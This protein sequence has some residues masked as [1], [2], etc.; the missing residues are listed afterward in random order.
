M[1]NL[2]K[3]ILPLLLLCYVFSCKTVSSN[4]ETKNPV[5][6]ITITGTA[7]NAK[8]GAIVVTKD[9]KTYY[10]NELDEWD[11]ELYKKTVKVTG[12]LK[13]IEHKAE[14]LKNEKGEWSQGMI[15]TQLILENAKWEL[16]Q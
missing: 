4:T 11:D 12:V 13:K 15:G 2:I 9:S 3:I 5:E 16:A 14:D 6:V 8:W 10:V 7:E 1:K